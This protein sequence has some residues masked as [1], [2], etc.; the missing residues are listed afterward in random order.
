MPTA[1]P[2]PPGLGPVHAAV[3]L[4][5]HIGEDDR[6]GGRPLY[7]LVLELC[8]QA[9]VAQA[10]VY[11]GI[12]GYGASSIIHRPHLFGRSQDAPITVTIVATPEQAVALE[13]QLAALVAEGLVATSRA[14]M[15]R[16]EGAPA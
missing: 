10:S 14:E 12:E 15:I 11:R 4:R 1:S 2:A 6:R 5:L 8:R 9:E 7:E 3:L 13:P 16:L